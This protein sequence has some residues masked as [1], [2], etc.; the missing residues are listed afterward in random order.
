MGERKITLEDLEAMRQEYGLERAR[1]PGGGLPY[2]LDDDLKQVGIFTFGNE[3][4]ERWAEIGG[5]PVDY[6]RSLQ[7]YLSKD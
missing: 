4:L 1:E 7:R 2:S 3:P 6:A 5:V